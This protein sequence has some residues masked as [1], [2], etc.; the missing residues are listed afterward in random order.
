M[1]EVAD[2]TGEYIIC[3]HTFSHDSVALSNVSKGL[4]FLK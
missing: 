1:R 2:G 3:V 4:T